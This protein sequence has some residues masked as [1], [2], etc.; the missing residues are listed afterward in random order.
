VRLPRPASLRRASCRLPASVFPRPWRARS[1]FSEASP[2]T[3]HTA[4]DRIMAAPPPDLL[5]D[6]VPAAPTALAEGGFPG[7]V[8][9]GRAPDPG[10]VAGRATGLTAIGFS[11]GGRRNPLRGKK[12]GTPAVGTTERGLSS[13]EQPAA[14]TVHAAKKHLVSYGQL[15]TSLKEAAGSTDQ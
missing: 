1:F 10:G 8:P 13:A 7:G 14:V 6:S 3:L 2:C 5:T 4:T 12:A 15:A 9:G 11:A